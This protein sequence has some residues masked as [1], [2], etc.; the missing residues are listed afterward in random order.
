MYNGNTRFHL[1]R[2]G[3]IQAALL[4][5]V[6]ATPGM[7][8][9]QAGASTA[10]CGGSSTID[11]LGAKTAASARAFLAQLQAAVQSNNKQEIAGMIGYPLLVLQDGKR[12]RISRKEAFLAN[13]DRILGTAVRDAILHQTAECLFGNS[14]GAMVGSGE[15]WFR[16]QAPEQWKVITINETA[17]AP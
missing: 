5:V 13:Y 8:E 2:L 16:E 15:V 4:V 7:L 14:S 6:C 3:L 17:S 12:N 11:G 9:A 10:A 1:C